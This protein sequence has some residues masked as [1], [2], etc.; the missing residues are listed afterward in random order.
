MAQAAWPLLALL[1]LC[2]AISAAHLLLRNGD[3]E[4]DVFHLVMNVV[5]AAM[6]LDAGMSMGSMWLGVTGAIAAVLGVRLLIDRK[7]LTIAHFGA[8]IVMVVATEA[9]LSD[10]GLLTAVAVAVV[11]LDVLATAFVLLARQ[12]VAA[13]GVGVVDTRVATFPHLGMGIGMLAM[14]VGA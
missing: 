11:A 13:A 12:R 5:M 7:P 14:L 10:L 2:A 4:V 3:R 8:A 1:V 9:M 6:V